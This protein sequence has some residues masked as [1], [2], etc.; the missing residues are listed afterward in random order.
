MQGKI[1]CFR[2]SGNYATLSMEIMK[3]HTRRM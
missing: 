2:Q 1:F 3:E